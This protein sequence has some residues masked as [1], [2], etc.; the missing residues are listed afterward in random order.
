MDA[1]TD[2]STVG[3][4]TAAVLDDAA[5]TGAAVGSAAGSFG[6]TAPI[7]MRPATTPPA[8]AHFLPLLIFFFGGG[9]GSVVSGVPGGGA[10]RYD[11]C[12]GPSGAGRG[13]VESSLMGSGF[14]VSVAVCVA[15][16]GVARG[17]LVSSENVAVMPLSGW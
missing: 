8:M 3:V 6:A 13:W 12:G 4:L 9:V 1:W 11:G 5:P 10:L 2:G 16:W 14:P 7:R 15:S 17:Q